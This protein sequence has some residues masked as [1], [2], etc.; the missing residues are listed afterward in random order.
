MT[1]AEYRAA[2][3]LQNR[4]DLGLDT[5]KKVKR[6]DATI[7]FTLAVVVLLAMLFSVAL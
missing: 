4:I 2:L 3:K 6:F 7:P 5:A 1:P